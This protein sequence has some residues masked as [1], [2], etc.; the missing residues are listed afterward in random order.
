MDEVDPFTFQYGCLLCVVHPQR[1][2]KTAEARAL[3][4]KAEPERAERELMY[5]N[6]DDV[7]A[8]TGKQ[9]WAT[10]LNDIR[11]LPEPI[12]YVGHQGIFNWPEG[13]ALYQEL[14]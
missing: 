10:K 5:G 12:P 9:R 1:S 6:Y 8:D 7:D 11:V 4:A 3:F 14:W 2:I 13:D